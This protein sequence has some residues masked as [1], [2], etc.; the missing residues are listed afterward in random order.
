MDDSGA[1]SWSP[2]TA[3]G[4]WR[5]SVWKTPATA[6]SRNTSS[7]CSIPSSPRN[8][9]IA[10]RAWDLSI[11]ASI[12]QRHGGDIQIESTPGLGTTVKVQLPVAAIVPFPRGSRIGMARR[13]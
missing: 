9:S 10:A 1:R 13:I 7:A 4:K 8:H 12:V 5:R 3:T 11:C 2:W 6:S